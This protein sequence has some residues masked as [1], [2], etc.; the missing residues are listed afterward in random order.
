MI[1]SLKA[2]LGSDKE[3]FKVP[4]SVQKSIPIKRIYKDGIFEVS[5]KFSKTWVFRDINYSVASNEDQMEMFMAYCNLLNSLATDAT[6]KITINNR[7]INIK[8]FEGSI[9]LEQQGDSLDVYRTEINDIL[10]DKMA[11][12]NN[13]TQEKY[14]TISVNKKNI[15]EAR[16]FFNRVGND[17]LGGFGKLSSYVKELTIYERLKVFHDFFRN[18]VEV[19]FE[20]DLKNVIKKGHD[21]KDYICSDS[22][23]F[24]GDYFMM[25]ERFGRVLFLKEYAS[26]IKDNMISELTDF[27]R[28]LMLSIDILPIPTDEAVKEMQNRILAVETD[29]TRWQN[30]QNM[31][32][33]FS[34]NIPYELEQMRK[35]VKEFLD[36]LTTR[37][38][39]M[40]FSL[41]T[42]VHISDSI[43]ELNADTE[44]ILS[45]GRKNLCQF[46][47]LKYQQEDGLNT[48]LPYGL[49]RI[50]ALRTMTT[51]STAVLMPFKTQEVMDKGG[52]Y[53]G[54]NAISHNLLVCNRKL[55]LNGN[56]FILGVSGSGKSFAAKEEITSIALTTND[57]IIVV[58][59]EREYSS[60]IKL[61]GGEIVHISASS[62]N[63]INALDMTKHYGDGENPII[64]KSEFVMSL[65]EQLMGAGKLGAKEK[66]IIDRCTANIYRKYMQDFKDDPPTLHEFRQE[67]LEQREQE[68]KDIALAIELFTDGSL[69]VFAHQTNIDVNN[70]IILY[71]ILDLGEQL[72]PIGLLVMLDSIL[73]RVIANRKQ[74]K[75]THIYIDEIYLFFLNQYSAQFLSKSWKRFRKYGGL[76]TG[77]TQN[78]EE[79]LR[80]DTARLML[81]N[82][83]FLLMLNQAATDRA[84]LA[85]I[86][87]I[88]DTQ[89]SYITN[90]PAG[91]GLIKIG[92]SIVPFINEFPR[93]TK[94]YK[95]MTTKLGEAEDG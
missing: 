2:L 60:L 26:F 49:L 30:K 76:V 43:E 67:L 83:E 4:G 46:A 71:D 13:I 88:S 18:G 81:A 41:V 93:D 61:L 44:T 68:A 82:S 24:K 85:N 59:P 58:D 15:D 20:L 35:E 95:L 19:A 17:L 78:V 66:S 63:H 90:A 51:E 22:I 94:L 25:D 54:I 1:K 74:G 42:L 28:N 11:D 37:D 39:R 10:L 29:I 12:S 6:T 92:G 86:L 64:L 3:R 70:R 62:N 56:G 73:N 48:V 38:Q 84:E 33:N 7:K 34:A 52:I 89:M 16:V 9:L 23:D 69:N 14:I 75:Y 32:N 91:R 55:L 72:K 27:S 45:I 77:I 80:S 31:N 87:N 50:E 57:D 40:M 65:C 21:F 47:S 79:C 53:Y 5:N 36:D 8:D